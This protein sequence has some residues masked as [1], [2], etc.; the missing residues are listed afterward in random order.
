M[1]I[2]SYR[3]SDGQFL[4]GWPNTPP[5]DPITE[6]IQSYPEHARPNQRLHR[7]DGASPTKMRLA[8]AQ[9]LIDYDAALLTEQAQGQFDELKLVKA[10]A[11]WTAGKLN[12]PLQT[13]KN[14]IL[15]LYKG[16]V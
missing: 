11:I 8:T 10:L 14:E 13:A 7:Y 12:I 16:L 9:E 15:A 1:M 2:Y 4:R 5:Y 6:A 3:L